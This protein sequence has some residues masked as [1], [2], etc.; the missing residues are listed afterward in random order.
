MKNLN[1]TMAPNN[2]ERGDYSSLNIQII[3]TF[4]PLI[5]N[6]ARPIATL[7]SFAQVPALLG[8][9]ANNF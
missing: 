6:N 4:N 3:R 5:R 9:S 1:I 7:N 8:E 2:G